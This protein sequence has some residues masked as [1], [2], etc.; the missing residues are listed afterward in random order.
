M[1]GFYNSSIY[2]GDTDSLYV[3]KKFWDMLDK[4]KLVGEELCQGKNDYKSGIF[5]SL[6]LAAKTKYC[7]TI[8]EYGIV[9]E[10]NF[11]RLQ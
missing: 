1:K 6:F 2:Y 5:Y 7:V 3:E 4:T 10:K 11:K 8:D 9:Q